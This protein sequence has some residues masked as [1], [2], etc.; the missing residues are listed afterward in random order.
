ME[1]ELSKEFIEKFRDKNTEY[2]SPTTKEIIVKCNFVNGVPHGKFERV[3]RFPNGGTHT[4]DGEY[5]LGVR[6]GEWVSIDGGIIVSKTF[7]SIVDDNYI[8]KYL[9][10]HSNG[11]IVKEM[12]KIN[13][14]TNGFKYD[15]FSTGE[16]MYKSLNFMGERVYLEEYF[17]KNHILQMMCHSI[18]I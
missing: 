1:L 18:A 15:Y 14:L 3:R 16:L 10:F 6:V 13:G 2:Y 5:Y 9:V 11:K 7:L 17:R 12:C 4:L 8:E